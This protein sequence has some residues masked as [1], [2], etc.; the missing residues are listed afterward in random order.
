MK[1]IS[2]MLVMIGI[3]VASSGC[4]RPYPKPIIEE[5]GNNETAFLVPMEGDTGKQAKFDSA[6]QLNQ[7]KVAAKRVTIPVTWVKTGRTHISGHYL[8]NARLIRVDRSPVARR[9]TAETDSGTSKSRQ[10]LE[11]ESKD[12]IGVSSGFAIT[13]YVTEEDTAKYLYW[14]PGKDLASIIDNQVFNSCQAIYSRMAGTYDVKEL[15]NYKEAIN[16]EIRKSVIPQF[17]A[18]GITIDPSM[19][20][21]GGLV[22]DNPAIQ[23]A[24]DTVF[25]AQTMEAKREADRIAQIKQNELD[26]SIEKNEAEKRKIK[27]DA[28]A[29]EIT[30][31][32]KAI[33]DGGEAYL[34][35]LKLEVEKER[36]GKWNG[37]VP[38]VSGGGSNVAP[39]IPIPM[40]DIM[41]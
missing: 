22:Y 10:V 32:A 2:L 17:K 35:L 15:R 31:K 5:I 3:T 28:E 33:M 18:L 1:K 11:A 25:I 8:P 36:I 21:I 27:A 12:S 37:N 6:E 26:L 16:D 24:I 13:A 29:Y 19:G 4:M 39:V 23:N 41:K 34:E 9:W 30:S 38:M 20:L 40:T 14:F 7:M